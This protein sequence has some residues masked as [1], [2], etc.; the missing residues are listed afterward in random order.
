MF[1]SENVCEYKRQLNILLLYHFKIV[2]VP[3]EKL[4][5]VLAATLK[6][7]FPKQPPVF[8]VMEKNI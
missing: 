8:C 1:L 2:Y 4:K 6:N 5:T 3:T 7:I